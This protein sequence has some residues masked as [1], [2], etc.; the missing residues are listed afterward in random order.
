MGSRFILLR[1]FKSAFK[2]MPSVSHTIKTYIC[3][4]MV[5]DLPIHGTLSV[6][7]IF[8]SQ[9][10]SFD[11]FAMFERSENSK[12][13]VLASEDERITCVSTTTQ[14]LE[15]LYGFFASIYNYQVC[16]CFT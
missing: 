5:C 7:A 16:V 12:R 4:E 11:G 13:G 3:F 10:L 2:R 1:L 8:A 14:F 6:H 9:G 15:Q